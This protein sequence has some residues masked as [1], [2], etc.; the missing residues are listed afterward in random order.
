MRESVYEKIEREIDEA[1]RDRIAAERAADERRIELRRI[2]SDLIGME[3]QLALV[4]IGLALRRD[5]LR[6]KYRPDQPRVPRGNPDGGQFTR[7]GGAGGRN[8]PRVTLDA[9]GGS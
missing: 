2:N 9:I 1:Q 5:S 7:E 6:H 8:D 3:L 4:K